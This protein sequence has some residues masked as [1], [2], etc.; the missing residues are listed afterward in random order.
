M[1][2]PS[3]LLSL[4]LC[5]FLCFFLSFVKRNGHHWLNCNGNGSYFLG[6][7]TW[8]TRGICY[9][10]PISPLLLPC[11]QQLL[12]AAASTHLTGLASHHESAFRLTQYAIVFLCDDGNAASNAAAKLSPKS[13][14]TYGGVLDS[15]LQTKILPLSNDRL[16]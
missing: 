9:S 13:I 4:F 16:V 14:R 12:R 10:F 2:F 6:A 1:F 7:E 11:H 5:L 3:F 8:I 15:L